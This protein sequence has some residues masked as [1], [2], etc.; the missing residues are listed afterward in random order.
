MFRH[1]SIALLIAFSCASAPAQNR[2]G[3]SGMAQPSGSFLQRRGGFPVSSGRRSLI[4]LRGTPFHDAARRHGF[5]RNSFFY[6]GWPYF[7]PD[8]NDDS[9]QLET[10]LEPPT[11]VQT[12]VAET[13]L[14]PVPSAAL[15]ELQGNQ[16]VKVS[17]FATAT[18]AKSAEAARELPPAVIVYRDGHSEELS[19][20]SIIGTTLFAKADYLATG[21]WTRKVQLADL[22]LPATVKQ[23]QQRGVKFDLPS[24]PNEVVLRP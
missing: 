24:G 11:P 12:P 4:G 18:P 7:P 16:W 17:A 13:R 3:M 20:Y 1:F 2:L 10:A 22:D 5:G 21:A 23:N 9:Y 8:Y 15:L 14:E 6:G 19:S